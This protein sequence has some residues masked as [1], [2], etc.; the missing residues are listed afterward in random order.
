[1]PFTIAEHT[2]SYFINNKIDL[3]RFQRKATWKDKDNFTLA[4]SVFKG[5]PIGVVIVNETGKEKF[6]L[7]GRQRRKALT[8]MYEDPVE[9]Y[10]WAAKFLGLKGNMSDDEV[11]IRF[12]DKIREYLQTE[13]HK[14]TES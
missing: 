13:F 3:P 2:T 7:D 14:S 8:T 12:Y 10:T 5:Y 11:R 9:V 1:M 6:L 4:I